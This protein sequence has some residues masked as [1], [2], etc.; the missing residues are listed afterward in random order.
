MIRLIYGAKGS[1]KTKRIIA[2][3][4]SEAENAH[5]DII[6][7]TDTHRYMFDI[8]YQIRVVNTVEHRIETIEGLV[9]LIKGLIAGNHDIHTIYIDGAHRITNTDINDM[10]RLYEKLEGIAERNNVD[11]VLT[12]SRDASELPEFLM[13][14]I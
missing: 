1:G 13:K 11:F 8:K 2:D 9:G 14:Y 4:N 12:V 5:G 7:L 6:F 10:A 3:A